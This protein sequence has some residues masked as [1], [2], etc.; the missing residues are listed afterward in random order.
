MTAPEDAPR[1]PRGPYLEA[2][3]IPYPNLDAEV[4]GEPPLV[5][6]PPDLEEGSGFALAAGGTGGGSFVTLGVGLVL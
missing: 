4:D 1:G 2:L 3:A 5:I 6:G